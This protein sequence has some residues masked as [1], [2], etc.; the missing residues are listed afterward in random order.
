VIDGVVEVAAELRAR[1][2]RVRAALRGRNLGTLILFEPAQH[3]P[4]RCD[5]V[6]YLTD[7]RTLGGAM[8]LV[9]VRGEPTLVLAPVWD[10]ARATAAAGVGE[11]VAVPR[12]Q[13]AP[14][15]AEL[16]RKLPQP[17]ALA[18]RALMRAPELTQLL[19]GLAGEPAD[20]EDIVP[21]MA[22]LRSPFELERLTRAAAI[23]DI[24]FNVVR[25][26]ARPGMREY[27]LAAEVDAVMQGEGAE[28][29]AGWLASGPVVSLRPPSDRRLERG[30]K[31]VATIAPMVRGY[32]AQ[33][34]RTFVLG[35]LNEA[36][37]RASLQLAKLHA[38]RLRGI[39]PGARVDGAATPLARG[40]TIVVDS[41]REVPGIG[42]L[43]CA[44]TVVV[45]D[46]GC[47][48]LGATP[49]ELF[50]GEA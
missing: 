27:E 35:P 34:S 39:G 41:S 20:G 29:N 36:Q 23:A 48:P 4:A 9:P 25:Q 21:P 49:P 8:L 18:G 33:L 15:A 19:G 32:V 14:R 17:I 6:F 42:L 26:L 28:D 16:A 1:A 12:A 44:D 30:D 43:A 45:D 47:R 11:A 50:W 22:A 13:L 3:A 2:E 24:G 40:M 5:S 7:L 46:G 38:L 37:R 31:I 10:R